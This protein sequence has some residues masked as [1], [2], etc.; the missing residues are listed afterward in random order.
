MWEAISILKTVFLTPKAAIAPPITI[1]LFLAGIASH[2]VPVSQMREWV[3]VQIPRR[4]KS[5]SI[6]TPASTSPP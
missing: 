6:S 5:A 2:R 1:R 4:Q 3:G